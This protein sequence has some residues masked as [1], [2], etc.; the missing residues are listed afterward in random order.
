MFLAQYSFTHD[1][2]PF[3][4]LYQP[5]LPSQVWLVWPLSPRDT[6]RLARQPAL[7]P[8]SRSG[9][10]EE[11]AELE[12]PPETHPQRSLEEVPRLQGTEP[13]VTPEHGH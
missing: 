9:S 13:Q 6:R 7:S 4:H 5:L 8:W 1:H 10:Q 2:T 11:G 12:L 3:Q